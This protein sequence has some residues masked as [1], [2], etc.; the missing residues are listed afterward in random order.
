MQKIIISHPDLGDNELTLEVSYFFG[1]AKLS[2]NGETLKKV[3]GYYVL[4]DVLGVPFNIELRFN[5][6]DP[7]PKFEINNEPYPIA[8][9]IKWYEFVWMGLPI[10]L[11]YKGGLIGVLM[12]FIAFKI[13]CAVFRSSQK[14][15]L[16]Y[17]IVLA[18]NLLTVAVF[19]GLAY[20]INLT[21]KVNT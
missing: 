15:M 6:F 10:I 12:G 8:K 16:K 21:V 4:T 13:N 1:R 9:A 3:D 18:I 14:T 17:L 7:I 11:V 2:L 20:L 19:L 5:G